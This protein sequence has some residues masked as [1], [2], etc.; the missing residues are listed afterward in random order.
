MAAAKVIKDIMAVTEITTATILSTGT[1][2]SG[3][4]ACINPTPL[5]KAQNY[6]NNNNRDLMKSRIRHGDIRTINVG[7]GNCKSDAY[8]YNYL[9]GTIRVA[10]NQHNHNQP[11]YFDYYKI[12]SSDYDYYKITPSDYD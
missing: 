9:I 8:A 11:I 10:H 5:T 7:G 6:K 2:K 1:A 12:T 3:S 4:S